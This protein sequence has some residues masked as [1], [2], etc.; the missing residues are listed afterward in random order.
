MP[1]VNGNPS[2]QAAFA[3]SELDTV[4]PGLKVVFRPAEF[5]WGEI[6]NAGVRDHAKGDVIVFL[7][8]DMVCLSDGWDTRLVGQLTRPDVGV[9]GG[10]LLYP[11]GTIQHA[12]I[13][14]CG[15][16]KTAHE[17]MGDPSDDG[18]Y[19]DRTLLVHEVGA[20]TGA[21]LSCRRQFFD[22]LGGFDAERYAITSSDADFCVRARNTGKAILY[23]PF[24]TW[25]HFESI[26]RGFD[27]GDYK[28]HWR[29]EQEHERWQSKFPEVELVDPS[30]NPHFTG[31]TPPSHSFH[32]MTLAAIR[33]WLEAQLNRGQLCPALIDGRS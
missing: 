19:L 16:G 4:Y 26:T 25:I 14:F 12:G 9:V 22:E 2:P 27:S 8:D 6:N 24:L 11:N 18:L 21:F 3:F 30:L 20:V 5:N 7:N 28:K 23:D 31:S 13:T 1:G 15:N 10:R 17:A 29:A 32:R 33:T